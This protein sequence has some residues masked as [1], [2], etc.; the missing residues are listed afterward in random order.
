MSRSSAAAPKGRLFLLDVP[1]ALRRPA[2]AA[3][4]RW[5]EGWR[6]WTWRGE[7]LP[8]RLLSFRPPPYSLERLLD[9][10]ANRVRRAPSRPLKEV[11]PRPRQ[12][13][14]IALMR[15]IRRAGR[16]G[17]LIGDAAGL[18]KTWTAWLSLRDDPAISGVL[19]ACP[20]AVAP[21]WRAT[22]QAAGDGGK[23]IAVVNC[24]RL[25]KLFV[26]PDDGKRRTL[27]GKARDGEAMAFDAVVRDEA[28]R[29]RNPAS[30]RA[31][32]AKKI[33]AKASWRLWLPAAAG[34]NPPRLSCLAPLPAKAA[35]ARLSETK[36]FAAWLAAQ[37]LGVAK[38]AF[39]R[40]TWN[41]DPGA[42]ARVHDLLYGGPLPLGIRRRPEDVAGWPEM[43]RIPFPL[44]LAPEA[45]ALYDE[46]WRDFRQSLGLGVRG[47]RNP[48][49]A[50][51][52]R[53]RFRQKASLLRL[54]GC[55]ALVEDLLENGM[56][57]AVSVAFQETLEALRERLSSLAPA[58]AIHGRLAPAEKEAERRRFQG[59]DAR[60]C[61]FAVEEGISLHQGE[62]A[63]DDT[64]RA[65][66][67]HD[68]RWPAIQM[69]QIEGR[70]HRDGKLAPAC[71]TF[72]PGAIDERIL[73]IVS[74]K[75]RTMRTTQGDET[76]TT[77]AIEA[78]PLGESP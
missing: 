71:W 26:L 73:E 64:P 21:H 31:K 42:E 37:D 10:R 63:E 36:D 49:D 52:Q 51:A 46:L 44:D 30:A 77:R 53:M 35:G 50:L 23:E 72:A 70:T 13:E 60:V 39:G 24:E 43:E 78:A 17:A 38:E 2:Q 11:A 40:W 3:G 58:C 27:R 6:A 22:I 74:A 18:G 19:I 47:Q 57:V 67:I 48:K 8:K 28:H 32:F 29:L 9:D 69:E 4:A 20:L 1:F 15:K 68:V 12:E 65:L 55:A 54:D 25:R 5:D 62:I 66:V 33:D 45:M 61:L 41:G 59:G 7:R 75:A 76:E 56:K 14:A 34:E 16:A